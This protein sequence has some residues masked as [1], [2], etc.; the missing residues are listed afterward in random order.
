MSQAAVKP[1]KSNLE[2][3]SATVNYLHTLIRYRTH[4]RWLDGLDGI[5]GADPGPNWRKPRWQSEDTPKP[6]ERGRIARR[7]AQL[8]RQRQT[9]LRRLRERIA[10]TLGRKA[11]RLP[12][13]EL[14]G[15]HA[16]S[17]FEKFVL[18]AAL[19]PS[20]DA[21]VVKALEHLV[22]HSVHSLEVRDVLE[23]L[24]ESV[25]E[26][27]QSRRYFIHSAN[28]LNRGLLNLSF[29]R[30]QGSESD[31]LHM[32]I[33]LPR[34]IS[35]YIL[36]E[37]DVDDQLVTFSAVMD[38]Q[39]ELE[40]VVLPPGKREEVLALIR[41]RE[42]YVRCRE[43][44]GLDRVLPYGKGTVL[45]FA[46]PSGSGKT[47]LAHGLA[48]AT[49]HRLMLVDFRKV[50]DHSEQNFEKNLQL[51]F[52]EA[53]LQHAIVFF[54]EAD[55][56][57]ADRHF[58]GLMPT[59]LR[60]FEKLDGIAILATNRGAVLDEALER[61]I[62]YK[63]TFEVPPP[64]LRVQIWRR[65]LPPEA[66][67]A[68][69]VDLKALADE[70]EF[71]GGFIKNAVLLAVNRAI[72]RPPVDRCITHADLRFGAQT[73]RQNRLEAHTDKLVPRVSL[74][75]V[76]LPETIAGQVRGFVDAARKRST[77]FSAWGFGEKMSIGKAM[78]ALF[79]GPSG[80]GK[81]LTAEAVAFELGQPLYT[82]DAASI[83]SKYVGET[84]KNLASVFKSA[85]EAQA[86]L[87][88]DEAD[89]LFGTRL[90]EGSHH[91]RYINQEI[92]VLL[93]EVEKFDGVIILASN[94]PEAFDPAFERRIRY[95][96]RF[97]MPDSTARA[98]IWRGM[99]PATAPVGGDIDFAAL[100]RDYTFTGGAIK[101][102]V[103]RAAF[104]AATA[105]EPIT[106][107][108]LR[109]CAT[110]EVPLKVE[111]AIGFLAA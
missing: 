102:V 59:L 2:Y 13:E 11:V 44:W 7:R 42:E 22:D 78:T 83:I 74:N 41:D 60:E 14:V 18:A 110:E 96:V 26:K 35:S 45:L 36:G 93:R 71:T 33:E 37:Y 69:D 15:E 94:R 61:R 73:Q 90:Q 63:L 10:L 76:I 65:H 4:G 66:P 81:T 20:L 106:E 46:G 31:F 91:A 53:R 95:R 72:Q 23:T 25:E 48:K 108:R 97:P 64:E 80:V 58:N 40:N 99:I 16:L 79:M 105:G 56:M 38:P 68:A 5:E 52:Q 43:Q 12:L 3:L 24:C 86:L 104:D 9:E 47:M 103:L 34:R 32:D 8:S 101:N 6:A 27:I 107:A 49:G 50:C 51:I 19:I 62:L 29:N 57:F 84:E 17:E 30:H 111:K 100:G 87:F 98:A 54:D 77:V 67:V 55:E 109:R 1:F 21:R 88:V 92:N 89:A 75:D 70:F 82:V 85:K 28:L 39:V